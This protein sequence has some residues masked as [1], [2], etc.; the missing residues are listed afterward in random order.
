[1]AK[2]KAYRAKRDFGKTPEPSGK[3]ARIKGNRY[4][5]QKHAATRL[6]YD[7]RLEHDG[8]MKSWAV[9]RGPSLVPGEKR[10]AIHVEDH[11]IEYNA[12]EG[13][14]PKGEYGGGTVMIWDKGKW[15]PEIDPEKGLKKGHLDFTL[16][17]KK[18][19]G[20]WHLVRLKPRAGERQEPW[21]LIKSDDEY[22]RTKSDRDILDDEPRSAVSGRSIEEIA[23]GKSKVWHSNR[24]VSEQ[25]TRVVSAK[26]KA[27]M[28]AGGKAL[29][30]SKA[31]TR[32][33]RKA[34]AAK[35]TSAEKTTKSKRRAA[36]SLSAELAAI[37]G[38]R[39]ARLPDFVPPCLATLNDTAPSA[40][41]WMHEI[42]FDGYRMQ[43]RIEH[44]TVTLKTRTG[45]D[46]TKRF[47]SIAAACAALGD[48]DA[49]LD[50]E[51]VSGDADGVSNF[52]ALQDDLK[53][54]RHDRLAYYVFDLLHLDGYDLTGA[55]L[56]DRKQVLEKLFTALP[57]NGVIRLSEHFDADGPTL[58]RHAC[59][60]QLEGILSKRRDAPYRSG[61][62]GDWLKTKCS[63]SQ[64]FV[65]A[66][67]E[68]SDKS[69]RA[70]RS[71]LLGY[72]DKDGLRY[73]GRV[74]T[75]WGEAKER[76]LSRRLAAL[77]TDK[78]PFE[79]VPP[80]SG[81][82][83]SN[84]SS[85]SSWPRSISVAGPAEHCCGRPRSRDCARTSRRGRWCGR[86]LQ[87]RARRSR[88]RCGRIHR[89][90]PNRRLASPRRSPR[91]LSP[92]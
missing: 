23:G 40:G 19:K 67:F 87:C 86:R 8:V 51:I 64:E 90:K 66:G 70:I 77:A 55:T 53:A 13:T 16:E 83:T 48:H 57:K 30:K 32:T 27:A 2:L 78:P 56:A 38:V 46:W 84:G 10:L 68:P 4:V 92:A 42:K 65:V 24:P 14:I 29:S 17:G 9:T 82:A 33:P 43:A 50:G 47:P 88:R 73:A 74:G 41:D 28:K 45:L 15:L 20:R 58:L 22:A 7:L 75:G 63:S 39:K 89:R 36:G 76:D 71:L 72:Y 44:D 59:Q 80:R 21:L 61:R 1:M 81:G 49:L 60:M 85:R 25:S 69:S 12:F 6:H 62:S 79:S 37:A 52:S 91:S 11:P 18:L 35:K 5:I 34:A 26:A 31:R 54:G 3:A